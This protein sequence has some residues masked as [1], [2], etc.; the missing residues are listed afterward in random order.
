MENTVLSWLKDAAEKHSDKTAYSDLEKALSFREVYDRARSVGTYLIRKGAV[1]KPVAV[2]LGRSVDTIAAFLGVVS[3]G[4]AYAPVGT[5]IPEERRSKIL[6]RLD[7]AFTL[8]EENIDEAFSCPADDEAL[9]KA[10]EKVC[11]TD[12]LYIIFTSGSGGR[13]KGVITSHLSLM[14]YISAYTE[15]MGITEEDIMASQSPLDYIAA[16][17][18]IYIPLFTGASDVLVPKEYFMQPSVLFSFLNERG[19]TCISW[20]TSALKIL[21]KLNAFKED[22]VKYV[23][24]VCFSGS[25]MPGAVLRQWQEALPDAV[26]VNQYGPTEATASCTYHIMDHRAEEDEVIPAG[27]PYRNYR[28]FLLSE[29]GKAVPPGEEGEI[30]VGGAG[31]TLGYINDPERTSGAYIL[32][33]LETSYPDRV[34]KTGDIGVIN[35]DGVLFFHGRKD[36]QIKYLGHRVEL[37]EI[38]G[39]AAAAGVPECAA[40]FDGTKEQIWFFFMGDLSVKEVSLKLREKL[41]GFMVPRKFSKLEELPRLPNGK[42]DLTVLKSMI[43]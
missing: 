5:D 37:D 35:E 19:V 12:P 14:N 24:K 8:D 21:S 17:R 36:R 28:V 42:T 15:M 10:E 26:F 18:D 4:C 3:S 9:R 27:I 34:Y 2:L 38:E 11:A 1:K 16:I 22:E 13:P 40:L 31:V 43:N 6:E 32:N 33:P 29:D 20:S 7:P 30:V 25:V 41:P 39:A 23:R